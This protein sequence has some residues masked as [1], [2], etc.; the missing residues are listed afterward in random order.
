MQVRLCKVSA[1]CFMN[2]HAG[3]DKVCC[4]LAE[5]KE[6]P[7][8]M[9]KAMGLYAEPAQITTSGPFASRPTVVPPP[10]RAEMGSS[11]RSCFEPLSLAG[12]ESGGLWRATMAFRSQA[13]GGL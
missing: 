9:L 3:V 4:Q 12:G 13:P 7:N 11:A 1:C 6:D 8:A 5:A 2:E 10:G